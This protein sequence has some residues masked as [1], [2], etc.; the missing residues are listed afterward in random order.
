[1]QVL[2]FRSAIMSVVVENPD[3]AYVKGGPFSKAGV[4]LPPAAVHLFWKRREEWEVE[5]EGLQYL[6]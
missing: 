5:Q 4:A 2:M 1:M 3:I 6:G